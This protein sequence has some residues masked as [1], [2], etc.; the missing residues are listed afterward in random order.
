MLLVMCLHWAQ[1][2]A[3]VLPQKDGFYIYDWPAL[4]GWSTWPLPSANLKRGKA[5]RLDYKHEHS[6]NYGAGK[7]VNPS[8]GLYS[9]NPYH[10]YQLIMSRLRLH[11]LRVMDKSLASV[12][13]VPYDIGVVS[14]WNPQNGVYMMHQS[15]GCKAV[16][17]V[18]SLLSQAVAESPLEGHDHVIINSLFGVMNFNCYKILIKCPNCTRLS[19][20]PSRALYPMQYNIPTALYKYARKKAQN[21]TIPY[22]TFGVPIPASIHYNEEMKEYPWSSWESERSILVSGWFALIVQNKIATS[23]RYDLKDQCLTF[24][25]KCAFIEIYE[26]SG[27]QEKTVNLKRKPRHAKVLST[28]NFTGLVE[29]GYDLYRHS[30]FCLH[31]PGD[32]EMRKGVFDSM[33]LGC[34]PVLFLPD[35]LSRKYPWYFTPEIEKAVSVN[36]K[37][38]K[39]SNVVTYLES[40]PVEVVMRKRRALSEFAGSLS[41]SIPPISMHNYVGVGKK[42]RLDG[43]ATWEPPFRDAVDVMLDAMFTRMKNYK[44]SKI[45]PSDEKI[46]KKTDFQLYWV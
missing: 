16:D 19:S 37:L 32:M 9:T 13:F 22:G 8:L 2:N 39:I 4:D 23:T 10:L 14:Q 44:D 3:E 28:S 41:Y 36:V 45:I 40:L 35:I 12:F 38:S 29:T 31:P 11:P 33:L 27:H 15:G 34:I 21:V 20:E 43:R 18:S 25:L 46:V 1:G 24:P 30:I 5:A 26:R 6:F 17:V 7:E 42:G